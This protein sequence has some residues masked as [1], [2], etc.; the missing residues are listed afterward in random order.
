MEQVS[1]WSDDNCIVDD[2]T[3]S[4]GVK[5]DETSA[6][7]KPDLIYDILNIV[8]YDNARLNMKD[9]NTSCSGS[10]MH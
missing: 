7:E 1:V 8:R 10:F 5:Y 3:D 6:R 2:I 4:L 9:N